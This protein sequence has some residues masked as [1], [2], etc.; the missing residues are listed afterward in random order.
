MDATSGMIF[1]VQHFSLQDGPGVRTTVFFKG[2][3]LQ[4]RWCSN[5]ESQTKH[6]QILYYQNLCICCG[7]CIDACQ[8][9]A[10]EV[11]DNKISRN[12]KC[13]SCGKCVE[14]CNQH[15]IVLS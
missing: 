1:D 10:I 4:C 13:I 6:P 2:C 8:Q 7:K 11:H 3:P 12:N 14:S 15:A 5:P 9:K